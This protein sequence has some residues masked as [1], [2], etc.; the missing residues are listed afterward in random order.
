MPLP[1]TVWYKDKRTFR[2]GDVCRYQIR[3]TNRDALRT[4][5]YFRAKNIEKA[6]LRAFHLVNGPFIVYCH[7]IP[8]NYDPHVR[9]VPESPANNEVCFRNALKPGQT[10]NVPLCLNGNSLD[11]VNADGLA[12]YAWSCD[13]MCLIVLN[14]RAQLLFV[15][16]VGEDL[17][18][19]RRASRSAL[20][21]LSK[22]DF[23]FSARDDEPTDSE[24][25]VLAHAGLEVLCA[26]TDALWPRQPRLVGRPVHLVIV[27][28]GIFLNLTADMLYLRDMLLSLRL[29]NY[30]VDGYR[31]NA[32]HT[33]RGIHRLGAAVANYV[34]GRIAELRAEGHCVAR[35]SFVGHSL[36]GPVQLYAL[37]HILSTHGTD[38]FER[39][40]ILLANFVCLASPMLGVL[41]E[42]SL[43]ISWFL[44]LG[45]L[46]KTGRD[47]TLLK[48][49][50]TIKRRAGSRFGMVRPVLE[51]LPDEPVQLALKLFGLR[52]VYANAVNDGIVPLR[53][54]ALLYLDWEALGD[55][56][57]LKDRLKLMAGA[58]TSGASER[59]SGDTVEAGGVVS[60]SAN[61]TASNVGQIP[62]DSAINLLEK[63]TTF[64]S[65]IFNTNGETPSHK[66][67]RRPK[68]IKKRIKRYARISAKGSDISESAQTQTDTA[69]DEIGEADDEVNSFNIPPKASA[70]ESAFNS[71]ICPIPSRDYID[72]PETR[73]PVIFHDKFYHFDNVPKSES[74]TG[75]I[76]KFFRY[77]DWRMDKQVKIAR[78]YHSP[79]LS[80][81]KVLVYLPPD[82]HNN[83]VVRRRFANGYGWGVIEHL[84]Q[85]I[86]GGEKV[87]AW[88]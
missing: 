77:Y 24:W 53:T 48:K 62:S 20:T 10:F 31:G 65:L 1:P 69:D 43:W 3:F 59:S 23:A 54:S 6:G 67:G 52:V 35:L 9:F 75:A 19:M 33:E 29:D 45:T 13:V 32:G 87:A 49:L 70:V 15:V 18:E 30:L 38:Y 36:G 27:T 60:A 76:S 72:D 86:F 41:S 73:T 12:T 63:Y 78:K 68:R 56:R 51:T 82:A 80:W 2:L 47:L 88:F 28:H 55:V 58:D 83:I 11:L 79:D 4:H 25:G 50:P 46:G 39:Q 7:V 26:G 16:M 5:I 40:H 34:A 57:D 21:S 37:K 84:R 8:C 17:P 44:D 71:L 22:G 66:K 85:E 81:R 64:L 14:R 42:I 61:T 74:H